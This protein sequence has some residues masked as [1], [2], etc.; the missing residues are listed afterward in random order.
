MANLRQPNRLYLNLGDQTFSEEVI[1]FGFVNEAGLGFKSTRLDLGDVDADGDL[2]LAVANSEQPNRIYFNVNGRFSDEFV[3]EIGLTEASQGVAWG[4]YNGDGRLD[5]AVANRNGANQLY[6]NAGGYLYSVPI[7]ESADID[8]TYNLAWGDADGDGDLDLAVANRGGIDLSAPI[9]NKL[10]LNIDGILQTAR[11]DS[12]WNSGDTSLTDESS[13]ASFEHLPSLDVRWGDIDADGDLDL[14]FANGVRILRDTLPPLV[15]NQ[16]YLNELIPVNTHKP[17][18]SPAAIAIQEMHSGDV[19]LPLLDTQSIVVQNGRLDI[20]YK[21]THPNSQPYRAI[22]GFYSLDGGHTFEKAVPFADTIST[23]LSSEEGQNE[24]TYSW[25]IYQS[26]FFGSSSNVV[27]RLE[28]YEVSTASH[29]AEAG[30]YMYENQKGLDLQHAFVSAHTFPLRIRGNQAQVMFECVETAENIRPCPHS[31]AAGDIEPIENAVVY[32]LSDGQVEG[33]QL[34][35]SLTGQV[36]GTDGQ[37]YLQGRTILSQGDQLISLW[38]IPTETLE[39][40][41]T[42][43]ARLFYMSAQPSESGLDS[44]QIEN[45]EGIQEITISNQNPLVLFDLIV[46]IEWDASQDVAFMTDL[47]TAFK[48]ASEILFDVSNGQ[49]AIGNVFIVHSKTYWNIADIVIVANNDLRPS[50]AI[51]GVVTTPMPEVVLN[52]RTAITTDTKTIQNAYLPGQIRMGPSWDPFGQS[53]AELTE[54]WYRALAHELAHYFFFLPDDYLGIEDG[55]LRRIDCKGSFMTTTRDPSY[56]EFLNED[57]WLGDC[58]NTIAEQTTDR[59][60]WET[61]KRFYPFLNDPAT[62]EDVVNGPNL[63]PLDVTNLISFGLDYGVERQQLPTRIF[64]IKDHEGNRIRVPKATVYMIQTQGTLTETDDVFIN[65]GTTGPGGDRVQVRGA[66]EGDLLCISDVN[67]ARS[68]HNCQELKQTDVAIRLFE[69]TGGAWNPKVEATAVASDSPMYAQIIEFTID[70]DLQA[71]E[72]IFI[73]VYPASYNS[74]PENWDASP[75]SIIKGP[76]N[77][78]NLSIPLIRP[79]YSINVRLW[80]DDDSNRESITNFLVK[81]IWTAEEYKFPQTITLPINSNYYYTIIGRPGNLPIGGPG[82][83]PIGGPGNLPIGGP[84]NL[85]IGGPGN[86]PIGGPGNLP[87]GGPGNL[88]IGGPGNLPIGGPGNLPIGGPGNLPIGG[89]GN[90]PIGGPGNLPIGGPGNLPIGGPGNLPIGGP[91][92]LPIGGPGNL[93]IGGP[94]NLPIGGADSRSFNAPILSAD[95]QLTIYNN[96]GFFEDNG[97]DGLQLLVTAQDLPTWFVQV[98]QAYRIDLD[99]VLTDSRSIAF[100]Y[101]QRDVP[102]GFEETLQIAYLQD[103]ESEWELLPTQRFVE[104]LVVAQIVTDTITSLPFDGVYTVVSTITLPK[105]QNGWNLFSYPIPISRSIQFG[106]GSVYSYSK[107]IVD[108][109]D[110][111]LVIP[112]TL[113]TNNAHLIAQMNVNVRSGPGIENHAFS[114]LLE[115]EEAEILQYEPNASWQLIECPQRSHTSADCWITGREPYI[116]IDVMMAELANEIVLEFGHVYWI[117]I[118]GLEVGEEITPFL[119][120]PTLTVDGDRQ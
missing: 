87:I 98:G 16:V 103:G 20:T 17:T 62:L 26:G 58:Q 105:M 95:A 12:L 5:L 81:P 114:Y 56:S 25:D 100:S 71:D 109:L 30:T 19:S 108:T 78:H 92:N 60:D 14:V 96:L 53:Q 3:Q 115:S 90:L 18:A 112:D 40:T 73:Q 28:A 37:G 6:W 27:F 41:F 88:P 11:D 34:L 44:T 65:M 74:F 22:Q 45:L 85:P 2:D 15:V 68:L 42:N 97:V 48:R 93:P 1:Q 59:N 113:F 54:D 99:S 72:E 13:A 79:D 43:R 10:Y 29:S 120:P 32:G 46:S 57:Q 55:V 51:G 69:Q 49:V 101:L 23:N 84:G 24:H 119:A 35:R 70:Q 107:I 52:A 9:P 83:L 8:D 80:I 4:D 91:G 111:P 94:G 118:Q 61:V 36:F 116:Q 82:N 7:W 50:A 106:L 39:I 63:L 33:A 86:L 38:P 102:E 104:N 47:E 89:P 64:E 75:I 117:F 31:M 77:Q 21:L 67:Q 66:F 110:K 76:G